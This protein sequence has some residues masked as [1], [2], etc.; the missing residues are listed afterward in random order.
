MTTRTIPTALWSSAPSA[1]DSR[2]APL[3][4]IDVA[5]VR[6]T[7]RLGGVIHEHRMITRAA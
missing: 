5:R 1:L 7:D 4:N 2:P 3:D 6:K